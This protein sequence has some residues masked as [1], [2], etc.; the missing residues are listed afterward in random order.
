LAVKTAPAGSRRNG[1]KHAS[2]RK[3]KRQ[4]QKGFKGWLSRWWW[5][6]V[7][8][9]VAGVILILL[10]LLYVYSQLDL[11]KTPPPIQT[12]YVY[13]RDGKV[14][15]TL[16][17]AVDRTIIPLDQMPKHL[18]RAVIAVEDQDFYAH[19]GV[20]VFG[21]LRAAWTDIVQREIVQGGSTITQQ[22]VKNVYAGEYVRIPRPAWRPT[23]SPSARSARRSARACS[24]SRSSRRPRRTRSSRRT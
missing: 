20:D 22:L 9:P 11:P 2:R 5:V 15:T 12:T 7:V 16:H 18:Q 10:T 1:P 19:P 6:F 8:V 17:S 14:L 21:I 24:R 13:D 3:P 23:S 4:R